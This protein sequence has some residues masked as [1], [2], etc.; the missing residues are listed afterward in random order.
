MPEP[1]NRIRQACHAAIDLVPAEGLQEMLEAVTGIVEFYI[2]R[3][4]LSEISTS[5]EIQVTTLPASR[6][7]NYERAPFHVLRVVSAD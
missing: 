4:R 3:S 2:E 1:H 7:I 5:S 6:G